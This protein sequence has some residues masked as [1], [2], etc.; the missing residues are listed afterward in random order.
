[1]NWPF[2]YILVWVYGRIVW[3]TVLRPCYTT[4]Y[5]IC[6][7]V[8][9]NIILLKN[10]MKWKKKREKK[11]D[12]K[13]MFCLFVCFC[14]QII[15]YDSTLN[16][17]CCTFV[18]VMKGCKFNISVTCATSQ[19]AINKIPATSLYNTNKHMYMKKI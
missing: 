1:M 18:F 15:L 9:T 13:P 17:K 11:R 14:N 8:Q 16:V 7:W 19:G 2:K 6:K 10:K 5:S 12:H 3:H 4:K